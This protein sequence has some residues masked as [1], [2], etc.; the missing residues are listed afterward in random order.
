[1]PVETFL[2]GGRYHRITRQGGTERGFYKVCADRVC[3]GLTPDETTYCR[4]LT[5]APG[6]G[7]ALEG[8]RLRPYTPG[9]DDAPPVT[10]VRQAH[11]NSVADVWP[12]AAR[13]A[14]VSGSVVLRCQPRPNGGMGDCEVMEETPA[15]WGFGEAALK[16]VRYYRASPRYVDQV[17]PGDLATFT[18]AF[19]P[20]EVLEPRAVGRRP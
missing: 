4:P 16:L 7:V 14:G 11:P 5:P 6:D 13:D 12:R 17:Q 9:P 1:M 3:I 20:R 8:E 10:W 2:A 18:V 19:G 15:G